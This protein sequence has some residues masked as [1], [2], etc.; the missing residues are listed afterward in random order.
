MEDEVLIQQ[1][2]RGLNIHDENTKTFFGVDDSNPRWSQLR[3]VA[4]VIQFGRLFY[5]GSDRG[6]YSKVRTA[7]PES[8]LDIDSFKLAVANYF[9]EHP[10]FAR[11]VE[12]VQAVAC[13]ERV[14]TNGFGR[15]RRLYGGFQSLPRQALNSPIQ[16]TAADFLTNVVLRLWERGLGNRYKS[17]IALQ[18]HDE[19][20]FMV[21]RDEL[22]EV[23]LIIHEEMLRPQIIKSYAGNE[24]EFSVPIDSEIGDNWGTMKGFNL[25]TLEIKGG[26]KH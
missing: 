14:S 3:A 10:G 13:E 9:S 16:G 15:V 19:L 8:G 21:H 20:L 24:F 6:I 5:G 25:E 26:S 18:I 1:L 22:K 12:N 2:E 4:K 7:E 11:F 17:Y 23:S